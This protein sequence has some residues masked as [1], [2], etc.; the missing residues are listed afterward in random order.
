MKRK[1]LV[2]M[3]FCFALVGC[4]QKGVISGKI[5]G[6]EDQLPLPG[7]TVEIVGKNK[8]T[9]SDRNGR[10]EFL[11]VLAGSCTVEVKYIGYVN[12]KEDVVVI[13]SGNAVVNFELVTMGTELQE[14]VIGDRLRGQAKAINQQKNQQ[15]HY[16]CHL[17]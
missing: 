3:L 8:Y 6:S 14:V 7:A 17:I 2:V 10:F 5:V 15:K 9:I 4:A 1:L 12:A 11:D 16:Q 13:G